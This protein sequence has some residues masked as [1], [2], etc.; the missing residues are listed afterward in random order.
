MDRL[1]GLWALSFGA[2]GSQ[3]GGFKEA[4]GLVSSLQ[5]ASAQL[6]NLAANQ[7][8]QQRQL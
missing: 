7:I 5:R 6:R 2:A 3:P 1:F 4:G 8:M